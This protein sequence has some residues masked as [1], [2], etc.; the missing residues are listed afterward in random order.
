MNKEDKLRY[1][2]HTIINTPTDTFPHMVTIIKGAKKY[3]LVERKY[4]SLNKAKIAVEL[5]TVDTRI[6]NGEKQAKKD[7]VNLGLK[8]EE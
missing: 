2:N 8:V 6:K 7:M 5:A 3:D 4:V 1:L